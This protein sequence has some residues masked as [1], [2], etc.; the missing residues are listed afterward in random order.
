M[1]GWVRLICSRWSRFLSVEKGIITPFL[2]QV[3]NMKPK[4]KNSGSVHGH[5]LVLDEC[6]P[7]LPAAHTAL[8]QLQCRHITHVCKSYANVCMRSVTHLCMRTFMFPVSTD[9]TKFAA[10]SQKPS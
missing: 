2:D 10:C 3:P 7:F 4:D 8:K 1:G 5:L 9:P 6:N